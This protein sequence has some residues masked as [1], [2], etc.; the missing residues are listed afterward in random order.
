MNILKYLYIFLIGEGTIDY[1]N[2]NSVRLLF[3]NIYSFLAG[4]VILGYGLTN[5]SEGYI[6][7]AFL[8]V[9]SGIILIIIFLYG[10]YTK[11]AN[12]FVWV[13]IGV[14]IVTMLYAFITG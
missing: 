13:K 7:T 14:V 12:A 2:D 3:S 5:L 6:L 4:S 11:D 10:R 1:K 8:E 9:I